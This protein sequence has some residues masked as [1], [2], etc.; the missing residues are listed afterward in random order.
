MLC[1]FRPQ[2]EFLNR[3]GAMDGDRSQRDRKLSGTGTWNFSAAWLIQNYG[4][5]WASSNTSPTNQQVGLLDFCSKFISFL[6]RRLK[7]HR[8]LRSCPAQGALTVGE[9]DHAMSALDAFFLPRSS[10]AFCSK[11][12]LCPH[13]PLAWSLPARPLPA[14]FVFPSG[15]LPCGGG[16]RP[17]T[18]VSWSAFGA[19]VLGA[20]PESRPNPARGEAS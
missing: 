14:W 8:G 13:F 2:G 5:F 4:A 6:Y 10:L 19:L 9:M 17:T 15:V 12:F 20:P 7:R 11:D 1:T 18:S 3:G 16:L